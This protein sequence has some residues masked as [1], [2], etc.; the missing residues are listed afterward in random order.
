MRSFTH[1]TPLMG[2]LLT[3]LLFVAMAYSGVA[4]EVVETAAEVADA[5]SSSDIVVDSVSP[6]FSVIAPFDGDV[7]SN[8]LMVMILPASPDAITQAYTTL[9]F[10]DPIDGSDKK[11]RNDLSSADNWTT[12]FDST[13]I[14]NGKARIAMHLCIN[15]VCADKEVDVSIDNTPAPASSNTNEANADIYFP[16]VNEKDPL[17]SET[18]DPVPVEPSDT[19]TS[20]SID[21]A[22]VEPVP[23]PLVIFT[24][25]NVAGAFLI[26]DSKGELSARTSGDSVELPV[27]EYSGEFE[28]FNRLISNISIGSFSLAENAVGI[29]FFDDAVTQR[30]SIGGKSF[31]PVASTGISFGVKHDGASIAWGNTPESLDLI[32]CTNWNRNASTCDDGE[33][34]SKI[35]DSKE[36]II[37]DR[38][39]V[40]VVAKPLGDTNPGAGELRL[41]V[42]S[43]IGGFFSWTDE[44]G[45][46]FSSR[47]EAVELPQASYDVNMELSSSAISQLFFDNMVLDHNG[48]MVQVIPILTSARGVHITTVNIDYPFENGF[49]TLDPDFN[50][51]NIQKCSSW[52]PVVQI[53]SGEWS[54][55]DFSLAR[56]LTAYQFFPRSDSAE[57]SPPDVSNIPLSERQQLKNL[58]EQLK[59]LFKNRQYYISDLDHSSSPV[60][61]SLFKKMELSLEC[62]VPA[63]PTISDADRVPEDSNAA[64][65]VIVPS[66]EASVDESPFATNAVESPAILVQETNENASPVQVDLL[67]GENPLESAWEDVFPEKFNG[68]QEEGI[69]SCDGVTLLN[70][71]RDVLDSVDDENTTYLG[72]LGPYTKQTLTLSNLNSVPVT[73]MVNVRFILP[74]PKLATE[75][76]TMEPFSLY[77]LIKTEEVEL[78]KDVN[79]DANTMVTEKVVQNHEV[80][81]ID[82][83]EEVDGSYDWEDYWH[84]GV[85]PIGLVHRAN[86][87]MV[88]DTLLTISLLPNET[89]IIDPIFELA[90]TPAFTAAWD[91]NSKFDFIGG[92]S[93]INGVL[94]L[95]LDN[96]GVPNDMIITAP[97]ADTNGKFDNG[98]V[99]VIKDFNRQTDIKGLGN[100]DNFSIAF[101]APF[102]ADMLGRGYLAAIP[103]SIG[104]QVYN[105]DGNAYANDLIITATRSDANNA[106]KTDAG[107]VYLI[108]DVDRKTGFRSLLDTTSFDAMWT[109]SSASDSIGGTNGGNGIIVANLDGNS[110]ANDLIISAYNALSGK[111]GNGSV[112]MILDINRKVGRYDLNHTQSFNAR[113]DGNAFVATENL[114][115]TNN[116]G[117]GVQIVNIDKNTI[118]NDLMIVSYLAD[119]NGKADS[120][121]IYIIKDINRRS[122]ILPFSST[123]NFDVMVTGGGLAAGTGAQLG[124]TNGWGNAAR[125]Y[126]MNGDGFVNDLLLTNYQADF[127]G[128]TNNGAIWLISDINSKSGVIDLNT[129]RGG[130]YNALYYGGALNDQ[131]GAYNTAY[132]LPGNP[133]ETVLVVNLDGNA[134]ANDL[135]IIGDAVDSNG[136]ANA[137]AVYLIRDINAKP[138]TFD[139]NNGN[140]FNARWLGAVAQ[141]FLGYNDSI[142]TGVQVVNIDNNLYANDLLIGSTFT[143][144]N[145]KTSSGGVYLIRD[146]NALNPGLYGNRRYLGNL[147]HFNAR[148][149]GGAGDLLSDNNLS[150]P[151]IMVINADGNAYANDLLISASSADVNGWTD[152]GAV[153]LVLDVDRNGLTG[154]LYDFNSI[155]RGT[156]KTRFSGRNNFDQLGDTNRG[157]PAMI[158]ANINNTASAN[159]LILVSPKVDTHKRDAGAVTLF[160]DINSL[161]LN[162]GID[163]NLML[164]HQWR[165]DLNSD[166]VGDGNVQN[167]S[168]YLVNTDLNTRAN[169]LIILS[170]NKDANGLINNG[171]VFFIKDISTAREGRGSLTFVLNQ[172]GFDGNS[173]RVGG[174]INVSARATCILANCGIVSSSVQYCKNDL[175]TITCAS[176]ID[177][178]NDSAS[179]LYVT[180]GSVTV[181][182]G[183]ITI[184]QAFDVN[185]TIRGSDVNSYMIRVISRGAN[186][187]N[188]TSTERRLVVEPVNSSDLQLNYTFSARLYGLVNDTIG[189]TNFSRDGVNIV[190]VDNGSYANDLIITAPFADVNGKADSGAIYLLKNID[191]NTGLIDL[192]HFTQSFSA[193]WNGGAANDRIGDMNGSGQGYRL[194]DMDGNGYTNDLLIGAPFADANQK[195]N[196]GALYLIKDIDKKGGAFDLNIPT[197][198]SL[199]YTGNITGDALGFVMG[200]GSGMSL[201]NIDGNG[202]LNDVLVGAT[203]ADANGKV[204]TGRIFLLRDINR[205]DGLRDLNNTTFFSAAWNGGVVR[206]ILPHNSRGLPSFSDAMQLVNVDQNASANDLLITVSQADMNAKSRVGKIYLIKDI[207][208]KAGSFDLNNTNFF[209][210]AWNGPMA[211]DEIGFTSLNG[212]GVQLFDLDGNG[213]ANDLLITA[214]FSDLRKS[215]G[216]AVYM[217]LDIDRNTGGIRDLNQP[218]FFNAAWSA[219]NASDLIGDTSGSGNAVQIGNLDGNANANDLVLNVPLEDY[220]SGTNNGAVYVILDINKKVGQQDLNIRTNWNAKF[221]G[222]TGNLLGDTE[223]VTYTFSDANAKGVL[224]T[225]V[226][227]NTFS[228][229]LL[230]GSALHDFNNKTN[231]GGV[232]L[233]RDANSVAEQRLILNDLNYSAGWSGGVASDYLG[234]TNRSGPGFQVGNF[235][236]GSY[237]NDLVISAPSADVNNKNDNGAVYVI[238]NIDT[239]RGQRDLIA[240]VKYDARYVGQGSLDYLGETVFGG[241]GV[242]IVNV[243]GNAYSNDLIITGARAD[244]G[245]IRDSG[246]T[247]LVNEIQNDVNDNDFANNNNYTWR[248][249]ASS[250]NAY[251]GQTFSNARGVQ[252]TNIDNGSTTND[253]IVIAAYD[254][255]NGRTNSGA[256]TLIENIS[257]A[258]TLDYT[259][260][261]LLPSSGCTNGKG[262]ITG[263]T[264][265]Q[266]AWI[267]PL[268][269][270]NGTTTETGLVPEGQSTIDAT[271]PF[272]RIDNQSTSSTSFTIL[273]DLNQAYP[274]EY[275]LKASQ[276]FSGWES[277]CSGT[278]STGCITLTTTPTSVGTA[279]YSAGTNDLSIFFFGDFSS[280]NAGRVDRNVDTNYTP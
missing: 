114:G 186:V 195:T 129:T 141:D 40:F 150:G 152:N 236:G 1:S 88:L 209:N 76:R 212:Q 243:D 92:A 101:A 130:L 131:I 239:F 181:M 233:I 116:S 175:N 235:D 44:V 4:Q 155:A 37:K 12:A 84:A 253:L 241:F 249:R 229:D 123:A 61:S 218:S 56:G 54:N 35:S 110:S 27:G 158:V 30:F 52:D 45:N 143:D 67:P 15:V 206:E 120:G 18:N 104:V 113:W 240:P 5:I 41:V 176:F 190:N 14:P 180:Q 159:D 109:G 117:Q 174:D 111:A 266:R 147:D 42:P 177:M 46:I 57:P 115:S 214:S 164:Y 157:G 213:Y 8:S 10:R 182:S 264:T 97:F 102:T 32:W 265:C 237:A 215:N 59:K 208:A 203:Y 75:N 16:E 250:T 64:A 173:V 146:I 142:N 86:N 216:G 103:G 268:V 33:I 160:M 279:T 51:S 187:T 262:N 263:G 68:K 85:Y 179:P 169:D 280:A 183:P 87:R 21:P 199:R 271:S 20:T 231:V 2:V 171:A 58:I 11:Y 122:G 232:I 192:N 161:D 244:A 13:L 62:G 55:T 220:N 83:Q 202:V 47:G 151:S 144:I 17:S 36:V 48:T 49:F 89:K 90:E 226:D 108:K 38:E 73:R 193:R 188:A 197:N 260:A 98:V 148:W 127:N 162:V 149:N 234:D 43:N 140:V 274:A 196:N 261:V 256:V 222:L 66:L 170:A 248:W 230:I 22:P 172:P 65:D 189:Y 242:Q 178:N 70:E 185:W 224:I 81:F 217:I 107:A 207:N 166:A 210:Y 255:V 277:T 136:L 39:A 163:N 134:T 94:I 276:L 278:P 267:E 269:D 72:D 227:G 259:F 6:D 79:V 119:Y 138:G 270:L 80:E 100:P 50:A 28:F 24:P 198:S 71:F 252:V 25:S 82:S 29:S 204:D 34:I 191:Q 221:Y 258:S 225:N 133:G 19:G 96:N 135:I 219:V 137:G 126:D 105:T 69:L 125:F 275:T 74:N 23:I 184:D 238:K 223:N 99:Y 3:G 31:Q 272:F 77:Q 93:D 205:F 128:K 247:Y 139:L 228:N 201:S 251:L 145:G 245:F 78:V 63:K 118:A 167:T 7:V 112:Y 254:D 153:Y 53:C 165:G 156:Y 246:A 154:V 124:S 200:G 26:F 273:L 60:L 132:T 121:N 91:G 211:G 9:T 257:S 168:V 194:A 95:D 106:G